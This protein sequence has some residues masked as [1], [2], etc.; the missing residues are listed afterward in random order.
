M[1]LHEK[2]CGDDIVD[3]IYNAALASAMTVDMVS[4]VLV[5]NV[6]RSYLHFQLR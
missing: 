2:E 6:A 4:S 3:S 5:M 1:S